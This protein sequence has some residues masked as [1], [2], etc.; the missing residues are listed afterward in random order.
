MRYLVSLFICG[1]LL[2]SGC[3]TG[4]TPLSEGVGSQISKTSQKAQPASTRTSQESAKR[5]VVSEGPRGVGPF[6]AS[7]SDTAQWDRF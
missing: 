7:S 3:I 5:M 2:L 6:G 4:R 1:S